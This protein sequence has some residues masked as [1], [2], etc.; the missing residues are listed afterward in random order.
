MHDTAFA[1]VWRQYVSIYWDMCECVLLVNNVECHCCHVNRCQPKAYTNILV[2]V[3]NH[4]F[5]SNSSKSELIETKFYRRRRVTCHTPQQTNGIH[6]AKFFV[7]KTTH[8]FT[9]FHGTIF[10]KFK[11]KWWIRITVN[12]FGIE[13]WNLSKNGSFTLKSHFGF[14]FWYTSG[15]RSTALA[16]RPTANLS[17]VSYSQK[18]TQPVFIEP[19]PVRALL[20]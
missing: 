14:F 18:V 10:V 3:R 12:F 11:H 9:H 15:V 16:F 8:R 6:F 2:I 4:F 7:S 1:I 5:G 19:L 20:A 13:F 17:I